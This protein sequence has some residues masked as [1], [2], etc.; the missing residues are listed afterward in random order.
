MLASSQRLYRILIYQ[1]K[2]CLTD[3]DDVVFREQSSA[4]HC[5]EINK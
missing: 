2:K 1:H 5:S 3:R 4:E